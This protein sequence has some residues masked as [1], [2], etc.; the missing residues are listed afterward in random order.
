MREKSSR[1][2]AGRNFGAARRSREEA[3]A[4]LR[5]GG[6]RAP[7]GG[8]SEG[9][10]GGRP[11]PLPPMAGA[12]AAP[13][14]GRGRAGRAGRGG[15]AV[16]AVLA[17]LAAPRGGGLARGA[18]DLVEV[19]DDEVQRYVQPYVGGRDEKGAIIEDELLKW[20]QPGYPHI[21]RWRTSAGMFPGK[22]YV[23]TGL[24]YNK[25]TAFNGD[26]SEKQRR[27]G[28]GMDLSDERGIGCVRDEPDGTAA[29]GPQQW[30]Y[31]GA[32]M[33]P[34]DVPVGD[35]GC[36]E[37]PEGS[38]EDPGCAGCSYALTVG[39]RFLPDGTDC[40]SHPQML[41][42][43]ARSTFSTVPL[44]WGFEEGTFAPFWF[45][46]S[47]GMPNFAIRK[48]CYLDAH[49]GA[50]QLCSAYP[51][52]RKELNHGLLHV[53][54]VPF[55]L[56]KGDLTYES[57]GGDQTVPPMPD[58][59]EDMQ[60][61]GEGTL[62]VALTRLRDG[63]RVLQKPVRSR[64]FWV[65]NTWEAAELEPFL[66]EKFR[67]DVYDY[68]C[69]SW[70]WMALDSFTIPAFAVQITA[71]EPFFGTRKGGSR[72]E[73]FG[74][75]FGS[76]LQG[77]TVFVGEKE[78]TGLEMTVQGSLA[79]LTPP[80]EGIGVTVTVAVGDYD[81][82]LRNGPFG[83]HQAGHCGG[84]SREHPYSDCAVAQ[85]PKDWGIPERGFTY[86][87]APSFST[88]PPLIATQDTY[89]VYT[90]N[91]VDVDG[92]D[93]HYSAVQLPSWMSF[94][95]A[96]RVLAGIPLLSD[97]QCGLD[98][99]PEIAGCLDGGKHTVVIAVTD[100][101]HIVEQEFVV[102]VVPSKAV[103]AVDRSFYWP[104]FSDFRRLQREAQAQ[105]YH[106]YVPEAVRQMKM[107]PVPDSGPELLEY[108]MRLGG[109]DPVENGLR[110]I[111]IGLLQETRVDAF[112]VSRALQIIEHMG[113]S[114]AMGDLAAR[115]RAALRRQEREEAR[116]DALSLVTAGRQLP[117]WYQQLMDVLENDALGLQV[118]EFSMQHLVVT[119]PVGCS[120]VWS[121]VRPLCP[122]NATASTTSGASVGVSDGGVQFEPAEMGAGGNQSESLE[123]PESVGVDNH[124]VPLEAAS[125]SDPAAPDEVGAQHQ[126]LDDFAL[127]ILFGDS[128]LDIQDV[129]LTPQLVP[130]ADIFLEC[131]RN[132]E[133]PQLVL[134]TAARIAAYSKRWEEFSSLDPRYE[135]AWSEASSALSVTLDMG[136]GRNETVV[137]DIDHSYPFPTPPSVHHARFTVLRTS[138]PLNHLEEALDS[139]DLELT[140]ASFG[141]IAERVE[142]LERRLQ[143]Y[144]R[145]C[146]SDC[147]GSRG[148]CNTA[149]FPPRCECA[150]AFAGADCS[151]VR[152]MSDCKGNGACDSVQVCEKNEDTGE[153]ICNG[154]S[155][156]CACRSPYY[157]NDCSLIP[158]KRRFAVFDS[159]NTTLGQQHYLEKFHAYGRV[160]SVKYSDHDG[161][162][163]D[164]YADPLGDLEQLAGIMFVEY[165]SSEE[166]EAARYL[167]PLSMDY[168]QRV[169]SRGVADRAL[170]FP[171]E[172]RTIKQREKQ[173]M[174]YFGEPSGECSQRG[175]C[176]FKSGHCYCD[177]KFFGD[178]CEFQYCARDCSGHGT[179]DYITGTCHCDAHY[180]ADLQVGCRLK[181]LRL[182]STLCQDEALD[183]TF[184][185][186]GER[187]SPIMLSCYIGASQGMSTRKGYCVGPGECYSS[188]ESGE[189]CSDCSGFE[190]KNATKILVG[191]LDGRG[192]NQVPLDEFSLR[193]LKG[194]R[195]LGALPETR[196]TFDLEVFRS[197]DIAFSMFK[198]TPG[199]VRQWEQCLSP[200]EF[201]CEKENPQCGARFEVLL[202]GHAVWDSIVHSSLEVALDISGAKNITLVT[203][204]F[205]PPYW[206]DSGIAYGGGEPPA[207]PASPV[208]ALFC[209]G[210][211]WSLARFV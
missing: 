143:H 206:R 207:L 70:G 152:C 126:R 85:A 30:A 93:L 65:T 36:W 179:C 94:D 20:E 187:A 91:A 169:P 45:L 146:L 27:C 120:E 75:G 28:P 182:A 211:A 14:G 99:G 32:S 64:R 164:Q 161:S 88:E 183:D 89:Y 119:I 202:D 106:K 62:G 189:L 149:S 168:P 155:S 116:W 184:A 145:R 190:H 125:V 33:G 53:Q 130:L 78:C 108:V 22:D 55:T 71:V 76:D 178:A 80:G 157:G 42:L 201:S 142:F 150:A 144:G 208:R 209:D 205:V 47:T 203:E 180:E 72:I 192:F 19:W 103:N 61:R 171:D 48:H 73:I 10:G 199:I 29:P 132:Q 7:P 134:R 165:A 43:Y 41:P 26:G 123:G 136:W 4:G 107:N 81:R 86:Q 1:R 87:D 13:R 69:C 74:S 112:E 12:A 163:L 186:N 170:Y 140:E 83:G 166:A 24:G 100:A 210:S 204:E 122:L 6:S 52:Q 141:S 195:G 200:N 2:G 105:Q 196:I 49:S 54:S 102:S 115:L 8:Q 39:R 50:F 82:N 153:N 139:I 15:L 124:S 147:N 77:L 167:E 23:D 191:P 95:P 84:A 109:R 31:K 131:R 17:G 44:R 197:K 68:R 138:A 59:R 127:E 18:W 135:A 177:S 137:V 58:P 113:Y 162:A 35:G 154:G 193:T 37:N 188:V 172:L 67:I 5:P 198:A 16:L 114:R 173:I 66:G 158:C 9:G 56:G 40:F 98:D 51:W 110:S 111:L 101:I 63:R 60:L 96:T 176:D 117:G 3:G 118:K 79:C 38:S 185:A 104:T 121:A 175:A 148:T 128:G 21:N 97:L 156:K 57:N 160:I 92:D 181:P 194:A 159:L 133:I 46:R 90:A 129:F 25:D 151:Q 34:P 174:T 11:P